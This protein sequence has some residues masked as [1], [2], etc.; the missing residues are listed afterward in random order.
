MTRINWKHWIGG[1]DDV[2]DNIILELLQDTEAAFVR[3]IHGVILF[4]WER[5]PH[6]VHL[7]LD[8]LHAKLVLALRIAIRTVRVGVVVSAW[9][10]IVFGPLYLHA[11]I[12]TG[13]WMVLAITGSILGLRRTLQ[14]RRRVARAGSTSGAITVLPLAQE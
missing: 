10:A 9:L 14:W 7:L 4:F 12:T 1:K 13:L 2:S 3:M 8:W 11:G 6:L 5:I